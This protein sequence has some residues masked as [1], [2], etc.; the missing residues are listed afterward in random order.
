MIKTTLG[1]NVTQLEVPWMRHPPEYSWSVQVV[2]LEILLS[3]SY[4]AVCWFDITPERIFFGDRWMINI[5][6]LTDGRAGAPPRAGNWKDHWRDSPKQWKFLEF[7]N[8]DS[9][10]HCT[11]KDIPKIGKFQ[12]PGNFNHF[13][14]SE[15]L[16]FGSFCILC[17]ES[18][19]S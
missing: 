5:I 18:A 15:F 11:A 4:F 8:W 14:K 2:F 10:H 9:I 6:S 16:S 19:A 17:L 7:E 13:S 1:Q 12:S 3:C